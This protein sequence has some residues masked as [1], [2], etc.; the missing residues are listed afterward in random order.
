[1]RSRKI[2]CILTYFIAAVWM[3]NG[4]FCKA[5]NLVPRHQ[6][7]VANILGEEYAGILTK[8]IGIAEVFMAIWVLSGIKTRLNAIIQIIIIAIMNIL[9]FILVPELLLWGKGNSI[10]A[11]MLILVIYYNEFVL[12]KRL[13]QSA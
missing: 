12:N 8:A 4:L 7:I 10:F 11:L 1:M 6:Q 13:A 5:L 2:H 3:V 9:E